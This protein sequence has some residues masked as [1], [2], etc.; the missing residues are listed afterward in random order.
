M[1]SEM[2][3]EQTVNETHHAYYHD[4][5]SVF[6]TLCWFCISQEGPYNTPRHGCKLSESICAN[7]K[8]NHVSLKNSPLDTMQV[9]KFKP[10]RNNFEFRTQ[11]LPH[12]A[13]YFQP[14]KSTLCDLRKIMLTEPSLCKYSYSDDV[15]LAAINKDILANARERGDSVDTK[16]LAHIPSSDRDH[17]DVF[18]SLYEIV[19][20]FLVGLEEP[21]VPLRCR[22][23]F[24]RAAVKKMVREELDFSQPVV[25]RELVEGNVDTRIYREEGLAENRNFRERNRNDG[26]EP[27]TSVY[28]Q[29]YSTSL[30]RARYDEPGGESDQ[31]TSAGMS[32]LKKQRYW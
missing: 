18:Q 6:Y 9:N 19:D 15:E 13:P 2:L 22:K 29:S 32:S 26:M 11:V 4:L 30:K 1:A 24:K 31:S 14:L 25:I 23:S 20:R 17:R 16:L 28:L 5:E 21:K 27:S 7:L 12:F 8:W 10:F 3:D